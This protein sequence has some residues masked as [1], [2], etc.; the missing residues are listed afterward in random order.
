MRFVV[1]FVLAFAAAV[2]TSAAPDDPAAIAI[3]G[4]QNPAT[5]SS[6]GFFDGGAAQPS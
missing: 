6:F 2:A 5:L 1:P 3:A 4:P